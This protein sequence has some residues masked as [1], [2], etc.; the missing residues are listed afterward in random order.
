MPRAAARGGAQRGLRP[1]RGARLPFLRLREL[2]GLPAGAPGRENVVVVRQDG[3]LAGIAVDA[4]HGRSQTVVK[5]LGQM[6][7]GL[8][9]VAGS[10]ILGSGRIALILDVPALLREAIA[11]HGGADPSPEVAA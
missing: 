2:F 4:L 7:R 3:R 6:L 8:P 1:H 9:G 10:T 5:P 11:R